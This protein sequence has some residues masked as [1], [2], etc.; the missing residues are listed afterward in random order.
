MG[1]PKPNVNP[2]TGQAANR[3]RKGERALWP[4]SAKLARRRFKPWQVAHAIRKNHGFLSPAARDLGV[5][6]QTVRDYVRSFDICRRVMEEERLGVVDATEAKLFQCAMKGE[7]WAVTLVLRSLATD[8]GYP[9]LSELVAPP[10]P[11]ER[12][13]DLSRLSQD[14]L[15]RLIELAS[16]AAGIPMAIEGEVVSVEPANGHA[17]A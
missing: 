12:E 17:D 6:I 16:K 13:L 15:A 8:R 1:Y 10:P 4:V 2:A 7:G 11:P 5:S 3:V 9:A 14:E